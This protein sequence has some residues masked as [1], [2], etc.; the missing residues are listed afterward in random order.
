MEAVVLSR[1]RSSNGSGNCSEV[2]V[3]RGT[4]GDLGDFML[5]GI[6]MGFNAVPLIDFAFCKYHVVAR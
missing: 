6:G 5:A 2:E 3:L 4:T 1:A